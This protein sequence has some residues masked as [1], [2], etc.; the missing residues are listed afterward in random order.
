LPPATVRT[1]T[2][3]ANGQIAASTSRPAPRSDPVVT[4]PPAMAVSPREEKTQLPS[5]ANNSKTLATPATRMPTPWEDA[6]R[7]R[8]LTKTDTLYILE[9]E[10]EFF[11]EMAELQPLL[12]ELNALYSTA[13][14]IAQSV[15]EYDIRKV[16]YKD[17]L[18][19]YRNVSDLKR[20]FPPGN[21]SML[22]QE[23]QNLLNYE[24]SLGIQLNEL[25]HELDL[26]WNNLM[27]EPQR[28]DLFAKFQE[29]RARFLTESRSLR[30]LGDKINARYTELRKDDTVKSAIPALGLSMKDL[31]PSQEFKNK[32]TRLKEAE[33]AFSPRDVVRNPNRSKAAKQGK[34]PVSSQSTK[35]GARSK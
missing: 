35:S 3:D 22:N 27:P 7:T 24:K 15:E 2:N 28:R 31:G 17:L 25:D 13:A 10:R 20:G 12:G 29:T 8:G 16:D 5:S 4:A 33:R 11:S 23:W 34:S 26:L 6:L 19:E 18:L 14:P 21:N 9:A 32:R 30:T 1:P